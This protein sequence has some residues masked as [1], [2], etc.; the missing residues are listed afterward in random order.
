MDAKYLAEIKTREQAAM[1]GPW[2]H[3]YT[4]DGAYAHDGDSVICKCAQLGDEAAFIAHSR[5][6]IPALIAEVERQAKRADEWR[7]IA[8]EEQEKALIAEKQIVTLKK[9]L[10][11]AIEDMKTGWLCMACKKRE[12]GKEW[13]FCKYHSLFYGPEKT[14]MCKNFDWR[15]I[16]QAQESEGEK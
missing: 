8:A 7:S 4:A 2:K 15:G 5:T 16:Q 9:E 11:F 13:C 10:I 12:V 3:E 14:V 6:D 1:P